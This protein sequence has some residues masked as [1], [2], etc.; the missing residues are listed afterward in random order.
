[1]KATMDHDD[2]DGYSDADDAC[3]PA[4]EEHPQDPNDDVPIPATSA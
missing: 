1:M 3:Q 2:E 4:A